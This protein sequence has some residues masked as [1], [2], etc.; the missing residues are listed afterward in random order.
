MVVQIV[1]LVLV[2]MLLVVVVEDK[3]E[4]SVVFST[5]SSLLPFFPF[6]VIMGGSLVGLLHRYCFSPFF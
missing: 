3:E 1:L 2:C 4:L 5:L 6:V